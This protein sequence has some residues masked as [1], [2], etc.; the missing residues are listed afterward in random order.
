MHK[1]QILIRGLIILVL[2]FFT[3]ANGQENKSRQDANENQRGDQGMDNQNVFPNLQDWSRRVGYK[4]S[5]QK[6]QDALEEMNMQNRF[7]VTSDNFKVTIM[8]RVD[9][10]DEN[11]L[12]RI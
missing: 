12:K 10:E 6:A 2:G 5:V 7:V 1:K 3:L 4:P 9:S 11:E 8:V